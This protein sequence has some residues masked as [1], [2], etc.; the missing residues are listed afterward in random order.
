MYNQFGSC[1]KYGISAKYSHV[2]FGEKMERFK[3]L[4]ISI[5]K[6]SQ[7]VGHNVYVLSCYG[8]SLLRPV[9]KCLSPGY[10]FHMALGVHYQHQ[11][12]RYFA[13]L[14]PATWIFLDSWHRQFVLLALV[15]IF[16]WS[17]NRKGKKSKSEA[18]F[19]LEKCKY[20]IQAPHIVQKHK[21]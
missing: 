21:T 14:M 3:C 5:D 18:S 11:L 20:L 13:D 6:Y 16:I 15:S 10:F 8:K 4:S 19:K 12:I 9:D 7:Q 2:I 17:E 1:K